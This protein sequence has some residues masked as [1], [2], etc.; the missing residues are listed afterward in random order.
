MDGLGRS[1]KKYSLITFRKTILK[2]FEVKDTKGLTPVR[3]HFCYRN[4]LG[5]WGS[6]FTEDKSGGLVNTDQNRPFAVPLFISITSVERKKL[7][8]SHSNKV[9]S[10]PYCFQSEH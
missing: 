6:Y 3:A 9:C 4:L 5:V 2:N 8:D 1:T 7:V 10:L